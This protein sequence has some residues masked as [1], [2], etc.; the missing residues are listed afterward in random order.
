[1]TGAPVTITGVRAVNRQVASKVTTMPAESGCTRHEWT[2]PLG[3]PVS[4]TW[5]SI[6]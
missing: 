1:M 4:T 6:D 2:E 5:I 3:N